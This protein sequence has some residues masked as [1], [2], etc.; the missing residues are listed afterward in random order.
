[1]KKLRI[2]GERGRAAISSR[3]I[4]RGRRDRDGGRYCM[5]VQIRQ[6]RREMEVINWTG[7]RE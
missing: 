6:Q 2:D 5:M 3:A 4:G 7:Q 1:M